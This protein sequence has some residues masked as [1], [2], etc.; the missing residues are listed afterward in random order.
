MLDARIIGVDRKKRSFLFPLHGHGIIQDSYS[1]ALTEWKLFFEFFYEIQWMQLSWQDYARCVRAAFW[2]AHSIDNVR[3]NHVLHSFCS[4]CFWKLQSIELQK[5]MKLLSTFASC[6]SKKE[7]WLTREAQ[8]FL[9]DLV[10]WST[11]RS[12]LRSS[13]PNEWGG[14]ALLCPTFVRLCRQLQTVGESVTSSFSCK[15]ANI[16]HSWEETSPIQQLRSGFDVAAR[17]CT[18]NILHQ[19]SVQ[20]R[21]GSSLRSMRPGKRASLTLTCFLHTQQTI[22]LLPGSVLSYR[23]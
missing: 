23:R 14:H 20:W 8:T 21:K 6:S 13:P 10:L 7:L 3:W 12:Q 4:P 1:Q 15:V 18:A 19:W 11:E 17:F 9:T 2:I 5:R 22:H 16:S